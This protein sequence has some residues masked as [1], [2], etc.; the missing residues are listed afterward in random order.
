MAPKQTFFVQSF[1]DSFGQNFSHK[2][3]FL[4]Q[5]NTTIQTYSKNKLMFAFFAAVTKP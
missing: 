3:P 2:F 5:H 1:P 4:V